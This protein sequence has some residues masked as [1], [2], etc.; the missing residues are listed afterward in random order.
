MKPTAWVTGRR[1]VLFG[2]VVAGIVC[3]T[4]Y[5]INRAAIDGGG[6]MYSSDA[7]AAYGVSGTIGQWDAGT[8]TGG[9]YELTGGFWFA[10]P[11]GDCNSDAAVNLLDHRDF[12]A[13]MA[14]PGAGA[15]SRHIS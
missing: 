12:V 2:L 9:G 6:V 14:G 8:M 13:C 7:G 4:E 10:L 5:E 11:P 1:A 15:F 3:A